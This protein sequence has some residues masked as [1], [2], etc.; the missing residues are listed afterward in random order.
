MKQLS[1]L[2]WMRRETDFRSNLPN[3]DMAIKYGVTSGTISNW[4]RERGWS[5]S[6]PPERLFQIR[7]ISVF[8]EVEQHLLVGDTARADDLLKTMTA[9]LKNWKAIQ[10][11]WS[12]NDTCSE[13]DALLPEGLNAD[14]DGRSFDD[15]KEEL[16]LKL[17]GKFESGTMLENNEDG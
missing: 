2:D 3:A 6:G 10:E 13:P 11:L 4:A 1:T 9:M 14:Y 12:P 7:M 8:E 15:L 17:F 5:R 16:K